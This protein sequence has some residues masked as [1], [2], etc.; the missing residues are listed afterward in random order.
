MAQID[1]YAEEAIQASTIAESIADKIKEKIETI[2]PTVEVG[3]TLTEYIDF[4]P[5]LEL[6]GLQVVKENAIY[7]IED[8]GV[9]GFKTAVVADVEDVE[10]DMIHIA[11]AFVTVEL[12]GED[13]G[14]GDKYVVDSVQYEG[15]EEEISEK[16]VDHLIEMDVLSAQYVGLM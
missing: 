12:E 13:L 14:I 16:V 8:D 4:D 9:Y 10:S 7:G 2:D 1:P 5:N 11:D 3:P 15:N 6:G